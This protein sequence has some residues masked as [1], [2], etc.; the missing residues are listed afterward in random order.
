MVLPLLKLVSACGLLTLAA[1]TAFAQSSPCPQ[2]TKA[3]GIPGAAA[4]LAGCPFSAVIETESTQSLADGT[5]IQKKFKALVYR[6]SAGRIRFETYAPTNPG[7]DFPAT[8]NMVQI[9]DPVA[10][11]WYV[12]IPQTAVGS[13]HRL[14]EPATSPGVPQRSSASDSASTQSQEPEPVVENLGSKLL[15]GL[16]VNGRRITRTIPVRAE[17]NDRVLTVVVETWESL[18]MGITLLQQNSDPR[19]G[20]AIKRMTNLKRTEPDA[21]VHH[22]GAAQ[23][24]EPDFVHSCDALHEGPTDVLE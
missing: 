18:D 4:S 10:G 8:S 24:S 14:N 16:L 2:A 17:G 6:D 3:F 21:A 23:D 15:E 22:G 20:N 5:R 7:T 13:R 12:F 1:T 19:S 9:F 11:F